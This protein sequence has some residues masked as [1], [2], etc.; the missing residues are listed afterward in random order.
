MLVTDGLEQYHELTWETEEV[1]NANCMAHANG[2][3]MCYYVYH[4]LDEPSHRF[5]V[6]GMLREDE[7]EVLMSCPKTLPEECYR[8]LSE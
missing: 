5:A 6:K 4:L 3:N 7:L 8:K 2:L 1:E